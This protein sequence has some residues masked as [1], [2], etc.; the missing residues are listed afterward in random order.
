[1]IDFNLY[2]FI[3][4]GVFIL[5]GILLYWYHIHIMDITNDNCFKGLYINDNQIKG[6]L[7]PQNQEIIK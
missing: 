4:W 7:K 5:I 6:L 1:M 2:K 3:I